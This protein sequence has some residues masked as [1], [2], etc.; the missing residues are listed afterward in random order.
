M[1]P[2]FNRTVDIGK[3]VGTLDTVGSINNGDQFIQQKPQILAAITDLKSHLTDSQSTIDTLNT[4]LSQQGAQLTATTTERDSLKQDNEA[5]QAVITQLQAAAAASQATQAA[6]PLDL[7]TAFQGVIDSLHQQS[8]NS[9]A[10]ATSVI[11]N[12]DIELKGV[13]SM[14][15]ATPSPVFLLPTPGAPVDS[16]QL[17]TL[18]MSFGA[19]PNVAA[20]A[21]PAPEGGSTKP[22]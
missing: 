16:A 20:A 3:V 9:G 7:A 6:H 5:K 8:Q 2:P 11:K 12:L 13:V 21:A 14:Q 1:P 19:V 4:Q 15:G 22:S 18:R 17:S 10:A